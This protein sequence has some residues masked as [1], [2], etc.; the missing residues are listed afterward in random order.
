MKGCVYGKGE[1][2]FG[3]FDKMSS[4]TAG[5]ETKT[6]KSPPSYKKKEEKE[7][8]KEKRTEKKV[9]PPRLRVVNKTAYPNAKFSNTYKILKSHRHRVRKL[10]SASSSPSL[11]IISPKLVT[12]QTTYLKMAVGKHLASCQYRTCSCDGRRSAAPTYPGASFLA[13]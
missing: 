9:V 13:S 1:K 10:P 11:Y 5:R 3:S 6:D 7:M 12:L 4:N 2:G 8:L